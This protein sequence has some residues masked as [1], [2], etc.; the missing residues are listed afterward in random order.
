M[1]EVSMVFQQAW[2]SREYRK[3][4]ESEALILAHTWLIDEIMR[5]DGIIPAE[6]ARRLGKSRAHVSQLLSGPSNMTLRTV[7]EVLFELGY[8]VKI[9]AEPLSVSVKTPE[10]RRTMA[11][12]SGEQARSGASSALAERRVKYGNR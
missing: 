8:R 3:T 5:K 1:A 9:T 4:Y 10:I 12:R 11:A 6:L 2:K 7:A